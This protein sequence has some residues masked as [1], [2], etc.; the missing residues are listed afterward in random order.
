MDDEYLGDII[1]EIFDGVTVL[2]SSFGPVYVRH[3]GQ[4]ELRKI[5]SKK[6]RYIEIG[7]KKGLLSEDQSLENLFKDKMWDPESEKTVN[8]KKE[9]IV[10]LTNSLSKILLP[11]KRTEHRKL[12]ELEKKKL[13]TLCS[14]RE[15]L[16]G[17]TAEKYAEKNINKDFFEKLLFEDENFERSVFKDLDYTDLNK[18]LEL[19]NLQ[20]QFFKKMSDEN[21]SKA[22]LSDYFSPYLA[23]SEDV[24]GMFG[25]PLKDLTSFEL[26]LLTYARTFLNIFKNCTKEIPEAV[27]KDPELLFEF[28]NAQKNEASGRKTG[29]S[30]GSGGTTYFGANKSDIEQLKNTDENPLLLSEEIKKKGGSLDMKQMMELHGV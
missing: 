4:L 16:I 5:F 12:I 17:L 25:K 7:I 21:I 11:S 10:N 28:N 2:N 24:F 1:A 19:H 6:Q 22:A 3:F 29:A 27:S 8:E 9:F 18:E 23:Y 14:E 13:Q 20:S 30:E 26:K 15:G